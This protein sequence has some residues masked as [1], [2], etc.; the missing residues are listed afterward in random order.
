[1]K[2][3]TES[4]QGFFTGSVVVG[5]TGTMGTQ[6][7]LSIDPEEQKE[8]GKIFKP[9]KTTD[10]RDPKSAR[11]RRARLTGEGQENVPANKQIISSMTQQQLFNCVNTFGQTKYSPN[12]ALDLA[13]EKIQI[14]MTGEIPSEIMKY[15]P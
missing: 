2:N 5:K 11:I 14:A 13:K 1:M 12:V 6:D 4:E 8:R 3:K 15:H 10:F 7:I 9:K